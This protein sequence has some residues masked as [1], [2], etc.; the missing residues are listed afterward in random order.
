MRKGTQRKPLPRT[1]QDLVVHRL[2]GVAEEIAAIGDVIGSAYGAAW[3]N[4]ALKLHRS[5]HRLRQ[6]VTDHYD[7]LLMMDGRGRTRP[8]LVIES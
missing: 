6:E 8:T 4:K 5:I 1:D 2:E 7:D 3:C